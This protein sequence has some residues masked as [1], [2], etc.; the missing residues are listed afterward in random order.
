MS[1]PPNTASNRQ[2][3]MAQMTMQEEIIEKKKREILEKLK[4]TQEFSTLRT[5]SSNSNAPTEAVEATSTAAAPVT[6][7]VLAVVDPRA[8][9]R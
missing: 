1:R 2:N 3:R 8:V 4:S 7:Q 9:F 5:R 6:E